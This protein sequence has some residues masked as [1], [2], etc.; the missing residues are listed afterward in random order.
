MKAG[1][2]EMISVFNLLLF[3]RLYSVSVLLTATPK[4]SFP[5]QEMLLL[6]SSSGSSDLA[7][8]SVFL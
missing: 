1:L 7:V 2:K 3:F 8:L 6:H 5:V 4:A